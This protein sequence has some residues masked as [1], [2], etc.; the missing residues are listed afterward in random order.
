MANTFKLIESQTL[1]SNQTNINFS[2]IDNTYTDLFLYVS[3]RSTE[4]DNAS[5]LR[6]YY[7]GD[8]GNTLS[9]EGRQIGGAVADY[10]VSYAQVGYVAASQSAANIWGVATIYIPNYTGNKRK[11][12]NGEVVMPSGNTGEQYSILNAKRW[13]VTDAINQ[14]TIAPGLGAWITHST[15]YLYGIK[16]S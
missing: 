16:K 3:A 9:L 8:T 6:V 15:F 1:T 7:N 5:S 10:Q 2:T 12:S 14:I 13:S 4:I 11:S